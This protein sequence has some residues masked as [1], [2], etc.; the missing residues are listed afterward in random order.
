M[1]RFFTTAITVSILLLLCLSAASAQ[2]LVGKD[3][4]P[5]GASEWINAEAD[6]TLK[7][8]KG[9]IIFLEFTATW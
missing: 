8:F 3:A 5:I 1:N 9:K 2:D 7:T 4:P 6:T